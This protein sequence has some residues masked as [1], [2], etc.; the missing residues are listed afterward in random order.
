MTRRGV[1]ACV[2]LMLLGA[3]ARTATAQDTVAT[4]GL[5]PDSTRLRAF[6]REY[7]MLAVTGD[8]MAQLGIRRVSASPAQLGGMTVWLLV[9]TRTGIVPATESL[10]VSSGGRPLQ[11]SATLGASRL[12]LAFARDSVL[13]AVTTPLGRR[14]FVSATPAGLVPTTAMLEF[15][16]P[17]LSLTADRADSIA[18][19]A[20]D[21]ETIALARGELAVIGEDVVGVSGSPGEAATRPAWIVA[22][23]APGPRTLLVW[24]DKGDGTV[25]RMQQP[26]P[27]H[28]AS[29]LEYRLTATR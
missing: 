15:L 25:L 11:Y 28:S 14:N 27:V 10:Y 21:H 24:V 12:T 3:V 8:S 2:A 19:F 29:L 13:G 23:R 4:P 9:E 17:A 20:V 16:V 5:S 6:Q 7:E 1:K 22:A 18:V 26:L